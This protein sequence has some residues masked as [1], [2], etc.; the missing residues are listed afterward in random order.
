MRVKRL[1]LLV[2]IAACVLSLSVPG[3]SADFMI[4]GKKMAKNGSG[5]RTKSIFGTLYFLTLYVPENLKGKDGKAIIEA[6]EPMSMILV[7]DSKLVSRERFVETVKEGFAKSASA[8]YASLKTKAFMDQFNTIKF[9]KGD[10]VYMTYT[11]A[12]LTTQ[13]KFKET[14]KTQNLGSI[15]GLDLKKALFAIWLGTNPVQDSLK[16]SLLSGK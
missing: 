4:G 15:A 9:T 1:S 13:F 5:V 3:M 11:P 6:N 14:G 12:G 8:G 7:L 2:I 16:A 10:V